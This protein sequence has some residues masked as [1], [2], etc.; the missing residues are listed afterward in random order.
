MFA[1]DRWKL[2]TTAL[3]VGV[4]ALV[5]SLPTQAM[6]KDGSCPHENAKPSEG[7]TTQ[8]ANSLRCLINKE[9]TK[10]G[11]NAVHKNSKLKSVE[12]A[13]VS[14]MIRERC[15]KHRCSHERTLVKRVKGSGYLDGALSY[16][17]VEN[18]GYENTPKKMIVRLMG[19]RSHRANI[20]LKHGRDIG[21][22][23]G[24]GRPVKSLDRGKY[25][26]YA[27]LIAD[28]NPN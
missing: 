20:L 28:R 7:S 2:G 24:R 11:L 19:D 4:I 13:H 14:K 17:F 16:K 21:V 15:F 27:M 6:A 9:R 5:A 26:T 1:T 10:R 18:L 3:A 23:T 25:V 12:G 8:F 22:A